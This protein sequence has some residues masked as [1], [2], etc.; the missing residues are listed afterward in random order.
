MMQSISLRPLSPLVM[1]CRKMPGVY[2]LAKY[3]ADGN[4]Y[5]AKIV[6]VNTADSSVEVRGRVRAWLHAVSVMCSYWD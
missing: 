4:Y 2:C 3:S 5:R 6:S 1:D